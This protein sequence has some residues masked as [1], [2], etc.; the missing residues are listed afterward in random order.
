MEVS[1]VHAED[2]R[3]GSCWHL[4]INE[5]PVF[6]CT[7]IWD[8]FKVSW[9]FRIFETTVPYVGIFPTIRAYN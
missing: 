5:V 4:L 8:S 9:V 3:G 6:P 7:A 1:S 2:I